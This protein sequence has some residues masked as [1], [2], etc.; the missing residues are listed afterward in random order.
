MKK[1]LVCVD[2]NVIFNALV[3][4]PYRVQAVL[5]LEHWNQANTKLIVPTLFDYEVVSALRRAVHLKQIS[6]TAGE[7]AYQ[8]YLRIPIGRRHSSRLLNL[9]WE[10]AIRFERSRIYDASYLAVAHLYGCELWTAAKRLY[11]AVHDKLSWVRWI[12]ES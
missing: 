2:A 12:E 7:D 4:G 9:S 8:Q 5:L 11:N 6:R 1:R 3:S 10:M